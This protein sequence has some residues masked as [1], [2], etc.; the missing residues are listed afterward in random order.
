MASLNDRE[1]EGLMMR[2]YKWKSHMSQPQNSDKSQRTQILIQKIKCI[3]VSV[4][5]FLAPRTT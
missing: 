1:R 4:W 2:N 5:L 3:T